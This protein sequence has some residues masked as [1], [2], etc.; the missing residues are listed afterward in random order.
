M[1]CQ[2]YER[3]KLILR[4]S[5][6]L[7]WI[8]LAVFL[9]CQGLL[10]ISHDLSIW[11]AMVSVNLTVCLVFALRQLGNQAGTALEF[12]KAGI[13]IDHSPIFEPFTV[14]FAHKGMV[15]LKSGC[16]SSKNR[17]FILVWDGVDRPEV[18]RRVYV[19]L[20]TIGC[21]EKDTRFV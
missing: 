17:V 2:K 19:W 3:H 9:L 10:L 21:C 13:R 5:P 6:S 11:R 15:I 7:R 20:R 1:Y 8:L 18:L 12:G 4:V 16:K 14:Y